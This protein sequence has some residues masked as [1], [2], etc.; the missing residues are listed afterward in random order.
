MLLG[1]I[2]TLPGFGTQPYYK[3]PGNIQVELAQAQWW[4]LTGWSCPLDN[5]LKL[6]SRQLNW[7]YKKNNIKAPQLS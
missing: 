7:W 4:T 2:H 1:K 5:D 6:A 3:A